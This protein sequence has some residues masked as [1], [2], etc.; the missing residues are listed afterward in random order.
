MLFR[1]TTTIKFVGR[2]GDAE[3]L[4]DFYLWVDVGMAYKPCADAIRAFLEKLESVPGSVLRTDIVLKFLSLNCSAV[5][6]DYRGGKF[7]YWA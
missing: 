6:H 7:L 3:N 2:S 5:V 1:S 4:V